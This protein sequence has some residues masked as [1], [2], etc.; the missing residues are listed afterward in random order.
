M[1]SKILVAINLAQDHKWSIPMASLL[2]QGQTPTYY[3]YFSPIAHDRSS[4]E[5]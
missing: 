1:A 5:T 4:G 2:Q 3:Y